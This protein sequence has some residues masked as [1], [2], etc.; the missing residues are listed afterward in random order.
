MENWWK[1]TLVVSQCEWQELSL[2]ESDW[3]RQSDT[4]VGHASQQV[5]LWGKCTSQGY[6]LQKGQ[7]ERRGAVLLTHSGW[8]MSPPSLHLHK[9]ALPG[10]SWTDSHPG[11][12]TNNLGTSHSLWC[13]KSSISPPLLQGSVSYQTSDWKTVL[14]LFCPLPLVS[15]LLCPAPVPFSLLSK[16]TWEIQQQESALWERERWAGAWWHGMKSGLSHQEWKAYC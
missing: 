3:H 1:M 13:Q 9:A 10:F 16:D 8:W 6:C 15:L 14:L 7:N 11:L 12:S 2:M 5:S 4:R